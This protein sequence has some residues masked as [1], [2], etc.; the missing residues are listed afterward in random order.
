M[1]SPNGGSRGSEIPE[2]LAG[3]G[4]RPLQAVGVGTSSFPFVAEDVRDAVLA[5]LE[6]GYRHLDTASLYGSEQLVGEAVAEAALRGVIAS[7]A[8]VFVT[9][10]V[11]C[12]QCHPDLVLPSLKESLQLRCLCSFLQLSLFSLIC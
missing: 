6:L 7:R 3:S 9:T 11:W 12:T 4:G 2:L 8:D 10:K 1:A 5:A